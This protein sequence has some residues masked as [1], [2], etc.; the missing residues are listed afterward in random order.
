MR[1]DVDLAAVCS[2]AMLGAIIMMSQP[3]NAAQGDSCTIH[4]KS[5]LLEPGTEQASEHCKGVTGRLVK[6]GT[7]GSYNELKA[8]G[9]ST[10]SKIPGP[11]L[12]R[13]PIS[14]PAK[15]PQEEEK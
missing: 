6:K 14:E 5:G 11:V 8:G 13:R 4:L 7:D 9:S 15:V 3:S 10:N 2:A 12:I 1:S